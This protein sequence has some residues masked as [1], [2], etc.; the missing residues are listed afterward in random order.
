[1]V[2]N[3]EQ[4]AQTIAR[5][6]ARNFEES[7]DWPVC[8]NLVRQVVLQRNL[9][10]EQYGPSSRFGGEGWTDD[11]WVSLAADWVCFIGGLRAT[12]LLGVERE[13]AHIAN[14]ARIA[15]YHFVLGQGKASPQSDLLAAL[16]EAMPD[17]RNLLSGATIHDRSP[18]DERFPMQIGERLPHKRVVS[19][20]E[21]RDALKV[22]ESL[23]PDGWTFESLYKC[24]IEWSAL[25][26][27]GQES[28]DAHESGGGIVPEKR[29][30]SVDAVST[31]R[32]AARALISQLDQSELKILR[33]FLIPN[34]LNEI[35]LTQAAE[36]LGMSTSTLHDR[37]S[38][39]QRKLSS[40]EFEMESL[41]S[42]ARRAF[43]DE[44][45]K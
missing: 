21:V 44:I 40:I 7:V 33:E 2:V 17:F 27:L 1:M 11:D 23:H 41:D 32:E 36:S 5:L 30:T 37:A 6:A 25:N 14:A 24:L 29:T 3:N 15:V 19:V 12:R 4:L 13:A 43:F 31:G 8:F 10:A 22:L 16:K 42:D 39:L 35:V 18:P 28:I 9:P 34:V 26:E 45:L 20:P 38:R